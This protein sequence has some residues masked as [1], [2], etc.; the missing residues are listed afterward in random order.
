M[1]SNVRRWI[2]R[3]S[4]CRALARQ[5]ERGF[6]DRDLRHRADLGKA[7]D[8]MAIAIS[9]GEIH[10]AIDAMWILTQRPLDDAVVFGKLAPIER[11]ERAQTADAFEIVT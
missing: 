8:D 3:R 2:L 10:A 7:F 6:G 9:R 4:R 5:I 11:T 1:K